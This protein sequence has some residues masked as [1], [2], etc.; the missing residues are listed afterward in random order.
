MNTKKIGSKAAAKP[1]AKPLFPDR[2]V[3]PPANRGRATEPVTDA[4]LAEWV[5]KAKDLPDIRWDKVKAMRD[6]LAGSQF[7]VDDRLAKL[8]DK[9]PEELITFLQELGNNDSEQEPE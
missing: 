1:S 6:A 3:P 2:P 9:L 4:E 7:D 8:G 5:Q